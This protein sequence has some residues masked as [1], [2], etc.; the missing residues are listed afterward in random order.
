[1]TPIVALSTALLCLWVLVEEFCLVIFL[2]AM[3]RLP[4]H[5][6]EDSRIVRTLVSGPCPPIV[7]C[8]AL[9]IRDY[10]PPL[11][12][13]RPAETP[14]MARVSARV[15]ALCGALILSPIA[16]IS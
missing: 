10:G 3:P 8:D 5:G 16:R 2:I 12:L 11:S 9:P 14:R 4:S 15:R 7:L 13:A 1:M 6:H